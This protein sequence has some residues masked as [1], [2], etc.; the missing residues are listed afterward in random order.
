MI[1]GEKVEEVGKTLM[2]FGCSMMLLIILIPIALL[3]ILS[4]F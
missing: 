3:L 1:D 4:V 2:S